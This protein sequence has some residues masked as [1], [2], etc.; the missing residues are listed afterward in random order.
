MALATL[1]ALAA[2]VLHATWN[3]VAKRAGDPFLAIWGQFL[4]AGCLALPFVVVLGGLPAGAWGWATLSGIVHLP[5]LTGLAYAYR[6]GDF[7]LAYPISR[8][9][10]ALVAAAGGLLLLGDDLGV[11]AVLAICVVVAGL[12]GLSGGAPRTQVLVAVWVA[13]TVGSYTTVDSHAIRSYPGVTYVFVVFVM[14]AVVLTAW[15][16][17]VGRGRDLRALPRDAWRRMTLTAAMSM[18]TYGLVL[19]AAQ[20][21]AVGYVAALRES[22][23]LIA[24]VMGARVLGEHRGRARQV[25]SGL[26]VAGL[27]LLVSAQ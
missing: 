5:Y 18:V 24:S 6:H 23:V 13:V 16:L 12:V 19:F 26:V 21:A 10:G 27:V 8:G 22:S 9:G 3:L 4:I 1:A 25:A 2:A 15:G 11:L 20:R 14:I 17:A 7:S